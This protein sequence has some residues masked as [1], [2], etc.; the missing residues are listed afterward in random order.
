M[1]HLE[2]I[3]ALLVIAEANRSQSKNVWQVAHKATEAQK[4]NS[5]DAEF[6]IALAA[7]NVGQAHLD[8]QDASDQLARDLDKLEKDMR[9]LRGD[10]P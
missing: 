9:K 4:R 2:R 8:Q 5:Q 6:K 1:S 7:Q 3:L 10:A